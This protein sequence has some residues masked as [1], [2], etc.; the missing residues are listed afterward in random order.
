[1]ETNKNPRLRQLLGRGLSIV[2]VA[3]AVVLGLVVLDHANQYPRTEDAEVFANFIGIAPQVDGP[4]IR[5]NVQD[6]QFVKKG[7]LL[8]QIDE[9]P[10]QY[11]LETAT[12][13]QATLEGQIADE[14]RKIAALVSGV[15]V[16]QANIHS[17]EAA[18]ANA[19]QG[20]A[21]ARAE[22]TYAN[23]N[24]HRLE[25][26]LTQQFVTVD[27][28]DKARTSEAIQE[29]A[30]KQAESRLALA[31]ADLN[32]AT[33]Q[34]EQA[35]HAVTTLEP[36]INQRGARAAA[37]KKARYDLDNC[38]V[39]APFDARVTNLTISEGAYAHVG[40][41]MFTLIDAR[42]WWAIGNFR[43]GQLKRIAPGMKAD[44]Y[45]MSRPNLRFAGVV[46]SV[47]FGVTP[48]PDV[49]GHLQPGLPNVQRTL[50]WVHL[51]SR[52]PVRVRVENPTPDLFRSGESAVITIRGN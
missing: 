1:M 21:R 24:L 25:P 31:K 52:F 44:V 46:D 4:L 34:H 50:N 49:I 48:D 43:E 22:W 28:V 12:S 47:G 33:A 51:A 36:L 8:Y 38:R 32:S 30:L 20:I 37:G 23:N 7:E 5:L 41:Q 14:Q 11:A 39:Y 9:R 13:Q 15:S 42:S 2:F 27:E 17:S 18:V 45:V 10:Y 3:T 19:E 16:A 6:N 40:E 29:E 26:L 35:M